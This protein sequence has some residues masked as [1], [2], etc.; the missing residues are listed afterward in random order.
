M[1]IKLF[2]TK[3]EPGRTLAAHSGQQGENMHNNSQHVAVSTLLGVFFLIVGGL[4]SHQ[5]MAG[6]FD[7]TGTREGFAVCEE[8]KDGKF[9]HDIFPDPLEI[10]HSGDNIRISGFGILYEG[11]TQSILQGQLDGEALVSAC[12][13][14]PETETVRIKQIITKGNGQ[15][16]FVADTVFGSDYFFPGQRTFGTCKWF[17]RRVSTGDPQVPSC[18]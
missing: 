13:G 2:T 4:S 11:V 6:S 1:T 5:A 14:I 3:V 7:L 9:T 10:S 8:L 17:Y 15:G 12:G 18:E 16:E